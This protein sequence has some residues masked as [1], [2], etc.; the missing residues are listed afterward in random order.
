MK[1]LV[2]GPGCGKTTK[3]INDALTMAKRYPTVFVTFGEKEAHRLR[4][5]YQQQILGSKLEIMS[6]RQL[7]ANP[8]K[9]YKRMVVD[10]V[11]MILTDILYHHI[12]PRGE[13]RGY[14]ALT[15]ATGI[16]IRDLYIVRET[17]ATIWDA[18][19]KLID[20]D[21]SCAAKLCEQKAASL[22][23]EIPKWYKI[24]QE[25]ENVNEKKAQVEQSGA[26]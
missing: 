5:Q 9:R 15:T 26:Q 6:F 4:T 10:N 8:K 7:L 13:E 3:A 24:S 23:A 17:A 21:P 11:D 14:L 22:R 18:A 25:L 1:F 19:A 2:T 20:T 16:P 12:D